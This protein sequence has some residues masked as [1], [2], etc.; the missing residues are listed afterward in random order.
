MAQLG[1]AQL[2]DYVRQTSMLLNRV[3]ITARQHLPMRH[4]PH[5]AYAPCKT[6]QKLP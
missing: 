3:D 2:T 1:L 6:L 5:S 4:L